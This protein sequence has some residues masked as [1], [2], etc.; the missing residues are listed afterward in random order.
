MRRRPPPLRGRRI[1]P[2]P[3]LVIVMAQS[4]TLFLFASQRLESFLAAHGLPTLPLVPV[5]SSQAVIG[6]IVGL[7]LFKGIGVRYRVLSEISLGW[8]ATELL[9][10]ATGVD[11]SR[12]LPPLPSNLQQ[13]THDF[14]RLQ[15]ELEK[16]KSEAESKKSFI[17]AQRA[18][19][20]KLRAAA[21][22]ILKLWHAEHAKYAKEEICMLRALQAKKAVDANI[23]RH[24]EALA[25]AA[26]ASFS[27][28]LPSTTSQGAAAS[29]TSSGGG[30]TLG[31]RVKR[32]KQEILGSDDPNMN[33]PQAVKQVSKQVGYEL[34]PKATLL[35]QV[36][37]LEA[38]IGLLS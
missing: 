9:D 18:H 2:V 28:P 29:T 38:A 34:N 35:Q 1:S 6:A 8:L 3:A 5:S 12:D 24:E 15:A 4:V 13:G 26:G 10:K 32:L 33:M 23:R 30:L 14:R 31:D 16:L 21:G 11:G 22:E 17:V 36:A 27:S 37:S 7:S 19:V 20:S 25:S